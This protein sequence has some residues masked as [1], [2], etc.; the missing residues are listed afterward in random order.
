[1]PTNHVQMFI[2][3]ERI[4]CID[5]TF[6]DYQ[7]VLRALEDQEKTLQS[8]LKTQKGELKE[9]EMR[10]DSMNILVREPPPVGGGK[11]ICGHY[12]H[13][14]HRNSALKPCSLQKCTEYTYCGIKEKHPEYFSHLTSL[15]LER[16]KR[17]DAVDQL[18]G[19][20]KNMEQF[21]T[22]SEYQ[23]IKSVTPRMYQA[24][25]SYKVNKAKLMRDV[26]L[27]R[28][29]LDGKIPPVTTNDRE[30]I[31]NLILKCKR[32]KQIREDDCLKIMSP[33]QFSPV[34]SAGGDV[35]VPTG[36]EEF[37]MPV[38]N[39]TETPEAERIT[40]EETSSSSSDDRRSKKRKKKS[41]VKRR[42]RGSRRHHS[43]SDN[44]S[45]EDFEK[46]SRKT[47]HSAYFPPQFLANNSLQLMSNLYGGLPVP[48]NSLNRVHMPH[49]YMPY[50]VPFLPMN[51]HQVQQMCEESS[52]PSANA[53]PA[54]ENLETLANVAYSNANE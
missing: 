12:H 7:N 14:G 35:D 29:C 48:N 46:S 34:K 42:K 26:R 6:L 47:F 8:Q 18:E 52:L 38:K 54:W 40:S 53:E 15:K 10:I 50:S 28:E 3:P 23:F 44:S 16:K 36:K 37:V 25:E 9:V 21:S 24:D 2:L 11:N 4:S 39:S 49:N 30:Q 27:L 32:S 43:S 17:K 13:R 5:T 41:K 1:M 51:I 31:R 22:S 20:L 19:Q 45:E 33:D